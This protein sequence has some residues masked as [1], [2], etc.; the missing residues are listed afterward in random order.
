ISLRLKVLIVSFLCLAGVLGFLWRYSSYIERGA[1]SAGARLDYWRAAVKAF[2]ER[3]LLGSGP[4]TFMVSY[5]RLKPPQAEMAR[6]AHNDYLQQAS[7]SG[8]LGFISFSTFIAASLWVRYRRTSSDPVRFALWLSLLGLSLHGLIE[9]NLYVPAIAWPQ[10]FLFRFLW[11]KRANCTHKTGLTT[12][13][14]LHPAK[15][16]KGANCRYRMQYLLLRLKSMR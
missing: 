16:T 9:F 10:F 6:L 5:R 13:T 14:L 8:V 7:D 3:P 15:I 11:R 4:G 1:T 12:L 2:C